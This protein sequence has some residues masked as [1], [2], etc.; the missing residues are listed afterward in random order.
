MTEPASDLHNLEV[1]L[2]SH[3]PIIVIETHEEVR[4]VGLLDRVMARSGRR[5][6]TWSAAQGLKEHGF[7]GRSNLSMEGWEV[8][9]LSAK[10]DNPT[11]DPEQ[12]LES[13]R[14]NTFGSLIVLL[15]FHPYLGNPVILRT[16]KEIA[17]ERT[18]TRNTIVLVSHDIDIPL[19]INKLCAQFDLALPDIETIQ[20][21]V[22]HEAREWSKKHQKKLKADKKALHKLVRNLL[23]LTITDARRLIRHAIYNDGAI[24]QD[25]VT[26]VM[27][28]KY[29]L[30]DPNGVLSL[31]VD[32]AS[33]SDVGGFSAMK[34]WLKIRKNYF[35]NVSSKNDVDAPKGILLLGI[36]GCG[37]S[38]AA[39]A[40]AGVWGVPLLR[41]D[42][43]VLY[44]KYIGETEKNIR[45]ALQS[46]ETLSPCVLWVDEIEKGIET[47]DDETGTS[48]RLLATLLTWMA[49]NNARVFIVA[50]ANDIASLPPEL[51]RKGRLDE[52]FFVDLP[53]E[54]IRADILK[55]HLRKRGLDPKKVDIKHIARE[56]EGFS[57]AELEQVIVSARYAAFATDNKVDTA[58]LIAEVK[59]T[60]PLSVVMAETIQQL[61]T[62]ARTRTVNAH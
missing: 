37:K 23:G 59:Q 18:K 55:V 19:E 16:L 12:M 2:A 57:G 15:D 20:K 13:I 1:L 52:I 54:S 51:I 43:G 24:T 49:E 30:V 48:R 56:S 25:D 38:L 4:A 28:V 22:M 40:I 27:E 6:L 29:Q 33:F 10:P 5:L 61:R 34:Q 26:E 58:D 46:A 35:L 62:W 53:D 41:L 32:T 3:F 60:Q 11:V 14:K 50:T 8:D 31:E 36:Q 9:D 44:N 39:K 47:G 21:M 17:Q 42:F 7:G 45:A